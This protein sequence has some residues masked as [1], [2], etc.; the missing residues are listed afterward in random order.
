MEDTHKRPILLVDNSPTDVELTV[1]AF[2]KNGITNN[3]I[4]VHDGTQALDLLLPSDDHE[5][6]LPSIVLMDINMPRM[7]GLEALRRLRAVPTT[8]ALPVIILS[9]S[10]EDRDVLESCHLNANGFVQ[11]PVSYYKFIEVAH[12]LGVNYLNIDPSTDPPTPSR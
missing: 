6:L 5:P 2:R 12:H 3:I 10:I 1:G 7:G 4:V 8:Q 11:K 9:D